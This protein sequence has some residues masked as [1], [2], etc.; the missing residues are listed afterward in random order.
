[1]YTRRRDGRFYIALFSALEQT[2]GARMWFDLREWLAFYTRFWISTEVAYLQ[3]WHGW[4]HMKL[5]PSRRVLCTPY[6]H[7]PCHFRQSHIRELGV[8]VFLCNQPPV[9][10]AEWPG[11]VTY[12]CG[13]TGLER[14]PK[15][16]SAQKVD[17]GEQQ[18]QNKS[19]SSCR[20]S[21]LRSFSLESSALTTGDNTCTKR[22]Q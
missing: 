1:M 15:Q 7:A 22:L 5:L 13:N 2:H 21:N 16:E 18:Q 8:W 6:T 17:P 14:I 9:L 4:C 3:R 10:W 12:C 20:D 19:H 11:S